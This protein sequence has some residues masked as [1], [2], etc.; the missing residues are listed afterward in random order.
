MKRIPAILLVALCLAAPE[1]PAEPPA[2][3]Q[4]FREKPILLGAHRGGRTQWPENTVVAYLEAAKRWPHILLEGDV[5]TSKDGHAVLMHDKTV[6]RTTNGAGRVGDLTLAELKAL[7]AGH[8]FTPDGGKTYPWRGKGVV[9]PTLGEVLE[10]TPKHRWLVELKGG[11]GV[12]E[13]TVAA[14]RAQKAE[15]RFL[16]ASFVPAFMAKV[17]TLAPEIATCYDFPGAMNMLL[18]LR[19]G[20][21]DTYRPTDLMLSMPMKLRPRFKITLQEVAAIRAKGIL[22]QLHTINKPEEMR[23]IIQEGVDSILT[24]RPELLA[25]VIAGHTGK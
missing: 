19:N 12:V 9:I 15:A 17:K 13:A 6:D 5:Q 10:A 20:N 22:Y 16:V 4:A 21:W 23:A 18:A 2:V 11:R 25:K 24:D 8:R 14:V 3:G 1:T 7:D